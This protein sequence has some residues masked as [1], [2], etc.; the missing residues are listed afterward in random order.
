M[1]FPVIL[2]CVIVSSYCAP[3]RKLFHEHIEDF[4]GLII[5]EK[6]RELEVILRQYAENKEFCMALAYLR[7]SNFKDMFYKMES[8]PE[9]KSVSKKMVKSDN[10]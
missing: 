10:S 8:L 7:T 1:K 4:V 6:G 9:F 3:P 5:A 2:L